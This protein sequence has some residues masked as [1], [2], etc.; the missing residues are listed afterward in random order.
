MTRVSSRTE[1]E[2]T[3]SSE[4]TFTCGW[5]PRP[6]TGLRTIHAEFSQDSRYYKISLSNRQ[7]P[8]EGGKAA[9]GADSRLP[10][11]AH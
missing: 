11:V 10:R 6:R 1:T 2:A 5:E 3:A 9:S 7:M 8:H 4:H